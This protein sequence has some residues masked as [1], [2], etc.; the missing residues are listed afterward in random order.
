VQ[1]RQPRRLAPVAGAVVGLACWVVH[2]LAFTGHPWPNT[3]YMKGSG[4][5]LQGL[6]YLNVQV[7]PYEPWLVGLGGLVLVLLSLRRTGPGSER[8]LPVLLLGAW[9]AAVTVVGATR[10]L[11]PTVLFFYRRYFIPLSVAP[12]LAVGVAA[13]SGASRLRLLWLAPVLALAA[14]I[15][16]Q[17][18]SRQRLQERNVTSL[19]VE[20]ALY[21]RDRVP[22]DAVVLVEGAGANRY[23]APRSMTIIDVLGLNSHVIAHAAHD[24]RPCA[25]V[26]AKPSHALLSD[27]TLAGVLPLFEVQRV[28]EWIEPSYAHA[29]SLRPEHMILFEIRG[30]TDLARK[31]CG[32]ASAPN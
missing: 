1:G 14:L 18:Q 19:H 20:P 10:K 2:C 29:I 24:R 22:A 26:A 31:H 5:L 15:G 11:D 7:V 32:L 8:V 13:A 30:P 23:F 6:L 25:Y 27:L 3:R 28:A 9:L 16:V 17:E 4:D 21:L 12:L